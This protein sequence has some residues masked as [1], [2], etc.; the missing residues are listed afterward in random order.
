MKTIPSA[1][2][3]EKKAVQTNFFSCL[4]KLSSQV[5][6]PAPRAANLVAGSQKR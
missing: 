3:Q 1:E 6:R 4:L 5:A 2:D